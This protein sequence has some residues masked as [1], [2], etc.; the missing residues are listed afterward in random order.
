MINSQ[1]LIYELEGLFQSLDLSYTRSI[2]EKSRNDFVTNVDLY[3]QE[4]ISEVLK[5][6]NDVPVLGE[7]NSKS[8]SAETEE[9]WIVDPLDGTSNFI[10]KLP[11]VSSTGALVSRG[12]TKFGF[13]YDFCARNTYWSELGSGSFKGIERIKPTKNKNGP[14]L[15]G[16]ST[17]FLKAINK[18]NIPNRT[19]PIFEQINFRVLGSQ[20][21][22][23]CYVA[24]GKLEANFSLEAKIWDDLAGALILSEAGCFY[25]TSA[26]NKNDISACFLQNS[27]LRSVASTEEKQFLEGML[28]MKELG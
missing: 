24:E 2:E 18:N 5:D 19:M 1:A 12:V 15:V 21:L 6:Y 4:R 11:L 22:Q 27:N 26:D 28:L 10:N 3:L 8:V 17:G 13:V 23:L 25:G 14:R 9:F 20:A 7:E 16:C